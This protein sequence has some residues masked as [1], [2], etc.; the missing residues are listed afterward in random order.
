MNV[1][2]NTLKL[3]FLMSA[4]FLLMWFCLHDPTINI[5]KIIVIDSPKLL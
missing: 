4:A 5:K 2:V 3:C 1:G